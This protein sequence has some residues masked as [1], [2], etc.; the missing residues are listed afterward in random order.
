MATLKITSDHK[1]SLRLILR[2]KWE[3]INK[4]QMKV[5]QSTHAAYLFCFS[6]GIVPR[7]GKKE[8]G[9]GPIKTL[10]TLL[11]AF[12][13]LYIDGSAFRWTILRRSGR[14]VYTFCIDKDRP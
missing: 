14:F 9:Y 4:R 11:L 12:M 2:C 5:V 8:V 3:G 7:N 10:L 6:L 13:V 1:V